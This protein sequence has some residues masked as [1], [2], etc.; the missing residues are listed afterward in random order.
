MPAVCLADF[1]LSAPAI[2]DSGKSPGRVIHSSIAKTG[3]KDVPWLVSVFMQ[4]VITT[5]GTSSG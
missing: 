2:P 1:F 3:W 5:T 4:F